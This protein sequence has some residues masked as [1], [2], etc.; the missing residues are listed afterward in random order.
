MKA[1]NKKIIENLEKLIGKQNSLIYER[2]KL[3]HQKN[4]KNFS[5]EI[6]ERLVKILNEF[7][8]KSFS[9]K[10]W[11]IILGPWYYS[12]LN[13]YYYYSFC[14]AKKNNTNKKIKNIISKL[15][16]DKNYPVTKNF[17]NYIHLTY[18]REYILMFIRIILLNKYSN[19]KVY[20][21]RLINQSFYKKLFLKL[22]Y[23]FSRPKV[24]ISRSRFKKLEQIKIY[25]LSS[26]KILCIPGFESMFEIK[27]LKIENKNRNL[28]LK[29]LDLK[30]KHYNILK[31]L[32]HFM[33]SSYLEN[34]SEYEK[35]G[36]KIIPKAGI[37]Y[38]DANYISDEIFKI[39][40]AKLN[41]KRFIGQHGG[42]F[43][44]YGKNQINVHESYIADKYILWGKNSESKFNYLPSPKIN[45][46]FLKYK[47][48]LEIKKKKYDFCY[49]LPPLK[50]TNFSYLFHSLPNN[51]N[52]NENRFNFFQNI[53]KNF[54]IKSYGEENRYNDQ[55]NIQKLPKLFSLNKNK[56]S[57][58]LKVIFNSKFLIFDYMSTMIFEIINLRIPFILILD[59]KEHNFTKEGIKLYNYLNKLN[60]LFK[61][62]KQAI[63]F[64]YSVKDIDEWWYSSKKERILKKISNEFCSL[65]KNCLKS[66]VNFFENSL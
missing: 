43:S 61:N 14:F 41:I 16:F 11:K 66:W 24:L 3:D 30:Y 7:H 51:L 50:N 60:I 17:S 65:E 27:K 37:I 35:A 13:I 9:K 29:N 63:N 2:Y 26:F 23:H 42:N 32:F 20:K 6:F 54:I 62:H 19:F 40:F 18:S 48:K 52:L 44:I 39:Q 28:I 15:D 33:P 47:S 56:F 8:K 45:L 57:K 38:S 36:N 5:E 59:K 21:I 31:F 1:R 34:F 58:N 49:I 10:S 4:F 12:I 25:F 53:K 64:I 22:F 55:V 46:F